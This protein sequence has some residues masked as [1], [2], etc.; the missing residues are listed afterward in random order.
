MTIEVACEDVEGLG[1]VSM[2]GYTCWRVAYRKETRV[3]ALEEGV[4]TQGWEGD[5]ERVGTLARS[6]LVRANEC[7]GD[8]F[9][10][11]NLFY[12]PARDTGR[13]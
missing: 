13:M 4:S 12:E 5:G 9:S 7:E 2:S 11:K 1:W 8:F 10:S 6:F 3:Q